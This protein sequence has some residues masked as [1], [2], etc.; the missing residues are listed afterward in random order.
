MSPKPILLAA[1]VAA[2]VPAAARAEIAV[3]TNG[4][5]LKISGWAMGAETAV[6]TLT[7]GGEMRIAVERIDRI[8]DDEIAAPLPEPALERRTWRFDEANLPMFGSRFDGIIVEAARKF[9]VD[10]ALVS[11]VIKAESDY[12]PRVVSHKGARGLMQLM[13]ATARR[14]GVTD[15]FDPNA[16]IHAGTRYLRWLLD[17]FEG[18]VRLALAGYNAGE[19]NVAKYDGVPPF[20]ETV[21]YI[22]RIARHLETRRG[23]VI[24]AGL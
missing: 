3:L 22:R 11:A 6:L 13:P 8:L 7:A 1:L 9:D 2:A 24:A 5:T 19:G 16:N 10:A 15:S 12:D 17:R 14:F 18:D 23:I 21:E 20:R 4:R